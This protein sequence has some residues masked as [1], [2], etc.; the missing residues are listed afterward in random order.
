ME[1]D[2]K[3][4]I[5]KLK[6]NNQDTV[7]EGFE[8]L[9]LK[10]SKLIYVCIHRYIQRK[11]DIEDLLSDTFLKVFE[12]RLNLRDDKNFKYYLTTTANNLAI[13]FLKAKNN[14]YDL[15]DYEHFDNYESNNNDLRDMIDIL[16][17]QLEYDEVDIIIKHLVYAYSF[18]EIAK[19]INMNVS[20]VKTKYFRAIKKVKI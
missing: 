6:S 2:D 7:D 1:L 5:K 12:N 4:I 9:Y 11:E 8:A 18:E 15:L 3:L 17:K 13:N 10:Y 19:E 16:K 20:T 14:D